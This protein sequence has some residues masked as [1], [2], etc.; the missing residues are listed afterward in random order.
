MKIVFTG[1]VFLGGD[2]ANYKSKVILVEEFH[3][4]DMRIINLESP[5]TDSFYQGTKATLFAPISAV[6]H[7]TENNV[8]YANLSNNH[9]QDKGDEGIQDTISVLKKHQIQ[10]IGVGLNSQSFNN[11]KI[12]DNLH[13]L[14]YCEKNNQYLKNVQ[15]A[16][17]DVIG[18]RSLSYQNIIEDIDNLPENTQ[19]I[20][21]LHWGRE[22]VLLPPSHIISLALKLIE[23]PQINTIIGMH[24][25]VVQGVIE[26]NSKKIYFSLGNFLFPNFYYKPRRTLFYAA[27]YADVRFT[28]Y[29]YHKVLGKTYKKWHKK[30]RISMLIQFDSKTN[31]SQHIFT[32]Q[33]E[34]QPFIRKLN[35]ID[36]E[37]LNRK[38]FRLGAFY[39]INHFVYKMITK[40]EKILFYDTLKIYTLKKIIQQWIV[41]KL[42]KK[43]S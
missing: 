28:T 11:I 29:S 24:P 18:V 22:H 34:N 14:T 16:S 4:A 26:R 17:E 7:L 38:V 41:L 25:H 31:R 35:A 15:V 12:T 23:H 27:D 9:F 20:L 43:A 19:V 33:D 36:T 40:I 42:N 37:K 3:S 39:Q 21:Y 5:I 30:N 1:D 6:K 8:S 13:V 32:C 10:P 2:L